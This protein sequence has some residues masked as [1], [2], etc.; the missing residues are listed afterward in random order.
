MSPLFIAGF[1][2]GLAIGMVVG[3][4]VVYHLITASDADRRADSSQRIGK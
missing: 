1:L 4:A 2:A 3:A